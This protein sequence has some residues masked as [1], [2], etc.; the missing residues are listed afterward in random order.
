MIS[1]EIYSIVVRILLFFIVIT[2]TAILAWASK[3]IVGRISP[4]LAVHLQKYVAWLIWAIGLIFAVVQLGLP[5][6]FLLLFIA[7]LGLALILAMRTPLENLLARPFLDLYT[8]YK[9][10][11]TVSMGKYNGKIVEI[12]PLNTILMNENSE[13]IVIPNSL[14][15]KE[16]LVDRSPRKGWEISIPLLV[17][18]NIDMVEF[19]EEILKACEGF[20]SYFKKGTHPTCATTQIDE[21]SRELLLMITL[22]NPEDKSAVVSAIQG[23]AKEIMSELL[24]K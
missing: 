17:D 11:D 24:E 3:F 21:R 10:G 18:K 1:P 6:E 2:V 4:H 19:E 12:N 20:R 7:L 16:V 15:L 22:K 5:V 9:V 13:L 14:F 8:H 23:K